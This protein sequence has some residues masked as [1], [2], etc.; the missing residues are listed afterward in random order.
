M[1]M[2][3]VLSLHGIKNLQLQGKTRQNVCTDIISKFREGGV[4]DARVLVLSNVGLQ[5]LNLPFANIL[6][7]VVHHFP[8]TLSLLVL[9]CAS[10]GYTLVSARGQPAHWQ[11]LVPSTDKRCSC[12][13]VDR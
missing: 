4:N 3:Q 5:G 8:S 10:S 9:K 13:S 2:V 1:V 11:D 6:V 7:M 12:V